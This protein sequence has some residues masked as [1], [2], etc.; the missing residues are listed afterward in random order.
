MLLF[1]TDLVLASPVIW[2]LFKPVWICEVRLYQDW[3]LGYVDRTNT[4]SIPPPYG[5]DHT[6]S[7][8]KLLHLDILLFY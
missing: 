5:M 6:A 7:T 3:P 4:T 8:E 2:T 1:V